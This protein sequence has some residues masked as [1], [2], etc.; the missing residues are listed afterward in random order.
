MVADL[1]MEAEADL[2]KKSRPVPPPP[3]EMDQVALGS[4]ACHNVD[5]IAG[6]FCGN[7]MKM[8]EREGVSSR[9]SLPLYRKWAG[10][11]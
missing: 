5:M 1:E 8:S 3:M 2:C 11:V 10:L 7:S 6:V 9:G 4:D